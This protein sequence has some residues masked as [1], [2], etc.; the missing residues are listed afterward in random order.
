MLRAE[1]SVHDRVECSAVTGILSYMPARREEDGAA[2]L[3]LD[4]LMEPVRASVKRSERSDL[5][6][7]CVVA[8]CTH[9]C[10]SIC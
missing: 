10:G 5:Q 7:S 4:R 3:P 9:S 8:G 6:H 2:L 1:D